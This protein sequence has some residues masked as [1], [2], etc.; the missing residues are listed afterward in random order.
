MLEMEELPKKIERSGVKGNTGRGRK[1][2]TRCARV[3]R[4]SLSRLGAVLFFA[5]ALVLLTLKQST[6]LQPGRQPQLS[7][8]LV[9]IYD[10]Q[11]DKVLSQQASSISQMSAPTWSTVLPT[12]DQNVSTTTNPT[13]LINADAQE[14][15]MSSRLSTRYQYEAYDLENK[16]KCILTVL[17]LDP[18]IAV[19]PADGLFYTSTMESVAEYTPSGT[20]ILL[21]TS[22]CRI[23]EYLEGGVDV[24]TVNFVDDMGKSKKG[25]STNGVG[26]VPGLL[27]TTAASTPES[28]NV[29]TQD[30]VIQSMAKNIY[31]RA[32]PFLRSVIE[33]GRI[34][35]SILDHETYG[36]QACD[37]FY[38]PRNLFM[39]APFWINEFHPNEDSDLILNVER[40]VFMCKPLPIANP[41]GSGSSA[42]S[43]FAFVGAPWRPR[44]GGG[45]AQLKAFARHDLERIYPPHN[46]KYEG[47][48]WQRYWRDQDRDYR[49]HNMLN[50]SSGP[51]CSTPYDRVNN[52]L[53]PLPIF[54][55]N[56]TWPVKYPFRPAEYKV[57]NGGF[58]LRSRKWMVRAIR[59]CPDLEL[60]G[61]YGGNVANATNSSVASDHNLTCTATR[62]FDDVYFSILIRVIGGPMPSPQQAVQFSGGM[63]WANDVLQVDKNNSKNHDSYC[64][65]TVSGDEGIKAYWNEMDTIGKFIPIGFHKC[66]YQ[67]YECPDRKHCKY[68]FKADGNGENT[69]ISENAE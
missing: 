37:N 38:N 69:N 20:C 34:R 61:L 47:R 45:L 40:D 28:T 54:P 53:C 63:L 29:I 23:R 25:G 26:Y 41:D 13:T 52:I 50:T 46:P 58:S 57:G 42:W 21:Q 35:I 16:N 43:K 6:F 11:N 19:F 18:R 30:Y 60:S 62:L 66:H 67:S 1:M 2:A 55:P 27:N 24:S 51:D 8:S 17:V 44:I 10:T 68:S 14:R 22:S 31:D 15:G 49:D 39:S 9:D 56:L 48:M 5:F 65:K 36:L 3:A 12:L 32:G 33:K 4:L 7:E 59:V 64:I